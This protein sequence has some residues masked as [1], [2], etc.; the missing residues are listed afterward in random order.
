MIAAFSI[1]PLGVGDCALAGGGLDE[2]AWQRGDGAALEHAAVHRPHT[3]LRLAAALPRW[4][5]FRGRDR[6]GREQLR[7]LL[8]DPRTAGAD[9]GVR[10]A[11]QVGVAMLAAE[12]GDGA[13]ELGTAQQALETYDKLSRL[14]K[15][16]VVGLPADL[17]A[18]VLAV[19]CSP[20]RDGGLDCELRR[21]PSR[22]ICS[23]AAGA[24]IAR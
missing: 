8:D 12:H 6:E 16:A 2:G 24:K 13:A 18:A 17:A 15:E 19:P 7:R 1:T 10:A 21:K 11:A 23:P 14:Q 20:I 3:A 4:W 22:R 5:R 9:P